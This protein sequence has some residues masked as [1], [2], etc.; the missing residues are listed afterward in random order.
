M[1]NYSAK[2]IGD[3]G[4]K[5]AVSFLKKNKYKILTK[6]YNTRVGEID[7]IAENKEKISFVEVKTRHQKSLAKPYEAVDFKKQK[8][9]IKAAMIYLAKNETDKFCSFDIC[10]VIVDSVTL[11]LISIN[12]IENAFEQESNYEAY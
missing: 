5:Y 4:E 6:N 7:I 3:R 11:K 8:R 10:E 9:I 12:Y 2:E 1:K